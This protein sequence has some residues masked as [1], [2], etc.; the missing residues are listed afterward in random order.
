MAK[1]RQYLA[2][3]RLPVS[4]ETAFN[5]HDRQGALN[6]LIPPWESV[7]IES[8]DGS[9]EVGSRV[10]LRT[11]LSGIPLRWVAEHTDYQ[12]PHRFCDRQVSGPFAKWQHRHS[13]SAINESDEASVSQLSDHIEYQLP[14]GWLG[15]ALGAATA[16]KTIEAM[17][18]YRH[19]ITQEDLQLYANHDRAPLRIAVSGSSG[20]V[21]GSLVGMLGLFGHHVHPIVR[22]EARNARDEAPWSDSVKDQTLE[23]MDAVV[24]LAG[25]SIASGRWN[26]ALKEEIR[27]SRVEKTKRLCELLATRER[28]P[29]V[30]ICAS[31]TGIYGTRGDECLDEN[32]APG[33]IAKDG[34]GFLT[35][36]GA[37]WEDACRPAVDAGIRVVHARFG[38]ILSPKGGALQKMLTPAKLLGGALGSGKQWWSWISLD[39]AIGALYHCIQADSLH[40]PVNLVSPN[41]IQNRDF[42]KEL[43]RSIGRPAIFPAPAPFLRA[44]LGEMADAL[45]LSSTRVIPNKLMESNYSF[46]FTE[47]SDFFRYTL[48]RSLKSSEPS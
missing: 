14:F 48:G 23:N 28:P 36:V 22:G 45:L 7:S 11:S 6:R 29:K 32:S 31:A 19:R 42:V 30:L 20:L 3:Q 47:L 8:S 38:I 40:G 41:P 12:P 5:Y 2:T 37:Q 25:K 46:R 17:F 35:D 26:K 16:R 24:H 18:S 21:G 4:V 1:I 15:D 27:E 13:F 44:A 33:S 9:L 34:C 10:I 39:D 43:G